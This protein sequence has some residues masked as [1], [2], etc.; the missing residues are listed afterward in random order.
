VRWGCFFRKKA[1]WS[2]PV[3]LAVAALVTWSGGVVSSADH[4]WYEVVEVPWVFG[5]DGFAAAGAW[6]GELR[7]PPL[8]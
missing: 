7:G 4:A 1:A 5:E 2:V 6:E 3:S 8:A